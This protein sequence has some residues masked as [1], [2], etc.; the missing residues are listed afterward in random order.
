MRSER[1]DHNVVEMRCHPVNEPEPGRLTTH[2]W[3]WWLASGI[4][5][6]EFLSLDPQV[7]QSVQ[8]ISVAP[9]AIA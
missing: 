4:F 9:G 3:W 2:S 1:D 8:I 5:L 6:A 7:T